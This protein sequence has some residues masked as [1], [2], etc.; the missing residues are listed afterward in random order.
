VRPS[1]DLRPL[2]LMVMG[3]HSDEELLCS[4]VAA[5]ITPS[6]LALLPLAAGLLV[7]ALY[8]RD[9]LTPAAVTLAAGALWTA[10]SASASLWTGIACRLPRRAA[11]CA[12]GLTSLALPLLIGALTG[13][14]A[15]GCSVGHPHRDTV[16]QIA[17]ALTWTILVTGAAAAFWDLTFGRLFPERRRTLWVE[18]GPTLRPES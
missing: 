16:F 17:A 13:A 3:L 10:L 4:Q 11:L 14:I 2:A 8:A 1:Y 5:G 12:Y 9:Y 7:I 6:A 18:S 15:Y